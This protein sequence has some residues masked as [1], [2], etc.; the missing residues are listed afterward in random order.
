MKITYL[1]L[2]AFFALELAAMA[3][4]GYWGY[5]LAAGALLRITLAVAAPLIVIVLWG[6]FLAPKASF[7]IFS[8]PARTALK[9]VV[10]VAAS[11]AL[12]ATGSHT[13]AFGFLIVS[14]ILVAVVFVFNLHQV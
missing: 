2:A 12:F 4:F 9:M 5:H 7:P 8:F 13:L 11:A 6:M 14:A 1:F 3:A 10:F